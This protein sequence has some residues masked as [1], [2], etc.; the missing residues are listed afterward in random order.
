MT[1]LCGRW[2]EQREWTASG[3]IAIAAKLRET[4]KDFRSSSA[5]RPPH[6]FNGELISRDDNAARLAPRQ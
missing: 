3:Q 5:A 6:G 2:H 1:N 4:Y